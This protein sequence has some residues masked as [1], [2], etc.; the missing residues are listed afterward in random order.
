MLHYQVASDSPGGASSHSKI[1]ELGRYVQFTTLALMCAKNRIT[2]FCSSL[3]IRENVLLDIR[4]NVLTSFF[5]PPC[6]FLLSYYGPK[7]S[8]KRIICHTHVNDFLVSVMYM[9]LCI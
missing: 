9:Y 3:D 6:K 8:C 7:T 1:R 4:E 5:G 2:T